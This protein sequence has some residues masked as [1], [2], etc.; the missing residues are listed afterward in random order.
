VSAAMTAIDI[1]EAKNV[2]KIIRS[3]LMARK[4]YL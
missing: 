3:R 4:I 1:S 2:L